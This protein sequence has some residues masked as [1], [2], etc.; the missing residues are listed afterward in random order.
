MSR[1]GLRPV[2][3]RRSCSIW[4]PPTLASAALRCSSPPWSRSSSR[5][6]KPPSRRWP[7]RNVWLVIR[8]EYRE[9]VRT[10]SFIISTILMPVLMGAMMY[11]PARLAMMR[12][13]E[14]KLVLVTSS[15]AFGRAVQEN[16]DKRAGR[17]GGSSYRVEIDLDS[18]DANRQRL[19]QRVLQRQIHAFVWA[20][21]DKIASGS[22]QYA[23]RDVN[24]FMETAIVQG[25]MTL[26]AMQ[27]RL[28]KK[29]IPAA[30]MDELIREVKV[31]ATRIEETGDT[32]SSGR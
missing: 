21:D 11:L 27:H 12:G 2:P 29:G 6:W 18:S 14:R 30:E 31:D 20:T 17:V 25:A 13:G 24:D 19:R 28:D 32:R 9:H 16:L 22:V 3:I 15:A 7:M 1:S 8:R 5:P 10:K 23:G 4:L 26:A